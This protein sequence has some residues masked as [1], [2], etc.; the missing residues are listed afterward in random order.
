MYRLEIWCF[1]RTFK[2]FYLRSET[3][4]E[5]KSQGKNENFAALRAATE[6]REE[7]KKK[8]KE[9][10]FSYRR[11]ESYLRVFSLK[12]AYKTRRAE[13][14]KFFGVFFSCER[15]EHAGE[16]SKRG[17]NFVQVS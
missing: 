13:R 5:E 14:A 1:F 7:K 17:R 15:S 11:S 16:G 8:G 9:F 10:W 12:F 4:S 6:K 2:R 3:V